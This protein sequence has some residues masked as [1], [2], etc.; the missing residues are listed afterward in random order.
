VPGDVAGEVPPVAIPAPVGLGAWRKAGA[1]P[2]E[3]QHAI[4]LQREEVLRRRV[5][6]PL[7]RAPRQAHGGER[8]R[9]RD[10]RHHV[11][12]GARDVARGRR[13]AASLGEDTEKEHDSAHDCQAAG[14]IRMIV[15]D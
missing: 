12:D 13:L 9:S 11:R 5:L 7:Q 2:V 15:T 4:G 3:R 10:L 1:L 6:R 8:Q 14:V